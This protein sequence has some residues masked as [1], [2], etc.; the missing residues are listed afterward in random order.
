ML[1]T[2]RSRQT[3]EKVSVG[4]GLKS[5]RPWFSRLLT[6]LPSHQVSKQQKELPAASLGFIPAASQSGWSWGQERYVVHRP[7]EGR[8]L[9]YLSRAQSIPHS[10]GQGDP[11]GKSS[12]FCPKPPAI[13]VCC[14][15][16]RDTGRT[17]PYHYTAS[18]TWPTDPRLGKLV[19]SRSALPND[20][21]ASQACFWV[22]NRQWGN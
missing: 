5:H 17:W 10:C 4:K 15:S 12:G 14:P 19:P 22:C 3:G 11:L 18:A 20:K 7:R 8:G 2:C 1:H 13:A 16:A 9:C 21:F 6:W